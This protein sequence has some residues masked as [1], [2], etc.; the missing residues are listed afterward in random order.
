MLAEGGWGGGM[1][2]E[3]DKLV[4]DYLGRVADLAQASLPT[5]DRAR[6]VARLRADIEDRRSGTKDTP[7][8]VRKV[9]QRLGS[10]DEVV[11]RA[12]QGGP[13]PEPAGPAP[14]APG[15]RTGPSLPSARSGP[16]EP[17]AGSEPSVP[18]ARDPE[19]WRVPEATDGPV[20]P[21]HWPT[22]EDFP[23]WDGMEIR[24][25][26]EERPDAPAVPAADPPAA[27]EPA[28]PPLPP[29]ERK[30]RPRAEAEGGVRRWPLL[31]ESLAALL[32]AGGAVAGQ[33]YVM[34]LGWL[35]AYASRRM[36]LLA[37][38]FAVFGIPALGV[39]CGAIWLWGRA[40]GRWGGP[41]PTDVQFRAALKSLVPVVLRGSAAASAAF[42]AW[43][44]VGG[45][46][47]SS[48]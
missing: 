11:Q 41:P 10:P 1:G 38:R 22:A 45:R 21:L 17:P 46:P 26:A 9:L 13:A 29:V 43:R 31:L 30:R 14:A 36:T 2:I 33:P 25:E 37:R 12:A 35:I 39:L 18:A 40:S 6:L 34:A 27:A 28:Q 42:L 19:W 7:A 44:A 23:G 15:I 20:G 3:S 48:S 16:P 32:L 24:F 4:Y 8:A 47:R 5:A